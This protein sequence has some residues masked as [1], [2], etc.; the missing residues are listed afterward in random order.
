MTQTSRLTPETGFMEHIE[1]STGIRISACFQCKKCTNGCPVTF[2]MDV[3]PDQ[4]IRLIHMGM[5]DQVLS[6]G[7]IWVCAACETCT[8]RCPNDIDIAGVMD[9]LKERAVASGV[10]IPQQ[11]TKLFHEAFLNDVRRRGRLSEGRML[12]SYMLKSGELWR[13]IKDG[14]IGEEISLGVN[15]FRKGRMSLIPKGVRSKSEIR[16][17]LK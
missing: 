7:T 8:T 4:V 9:Y 12:Q 1:A 3:Y 15:M 16:A 11:R 6:C 17:I 13:K 5:R 14:E 10:S 2:A